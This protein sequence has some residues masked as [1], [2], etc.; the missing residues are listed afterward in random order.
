[1]L[2]INDE[3]WKDIPGFENRYQVSTHGRIR[4]IQDNHGK[5]RELIR[6]TWINNSGYR[7]VQL[8][9]KDER[10]NMS[11]HVAVATTFISNPENKP[12]VNH[13]DG[14]KLNNHVSNLEWATYSENLKHAHSKGLKVIK[15]WCKGLKHGITS[16]FH[17]VTYDASRDRWIGAVKHDG[18]MYAKR[19]SVKKYGEYAE[20]L[21]AQAVNDLLDQLGITDRARNIIN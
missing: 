13:I 4:S 9:I 21:A 14:N 10:Y 8:F 12:T 5:Q 3:V 16:M 15:C 1:M 7:H 20:I 17:N 19:F 2:K 11:I 18:K 6:N